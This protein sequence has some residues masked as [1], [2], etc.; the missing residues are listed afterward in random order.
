[1]KFPFSIAIVPFSDIKQRGSIFKRDLQAVF[2]VITSGIPKK[3]FSFPLSCFIFSTDSNS[4]SNEII[5]LTCFSFFGNSL[6]L[7]GPTHEKTKSTE[8]KI[9]SSSPGKKASEY[10]TFIMLYFPCF[11]N[12][13][14]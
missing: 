12:A 3:H 1:M 5:D 6:R 9:L 14:L 4:F 11:E 10:F 2:E 8:F 7:F 13:V